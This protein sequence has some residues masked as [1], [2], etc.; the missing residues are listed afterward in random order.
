MIMTQVTADDWRGFALTMIDAGWCPQTLTPLRDTGWC[1][2]CQIWWTV[3]GSDREV[4]RTRYPL[5]GV[6]EPEP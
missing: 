5:P 2:D 4:V 1:T 6:R 3:E